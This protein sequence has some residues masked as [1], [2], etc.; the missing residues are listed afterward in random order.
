MVAVDSDNEEVESD[1]GNGSDSNGKWQCDCYQGGCGLTDGDVCDC[2]STFG[3]CSCTTYRVLKSC[4][5]KKDT[6]NQGN[7]Y[8]Y[9]GN[10]DEPGRLNLD[11]LPEN[12]PLVECGP[13]CPCGLEC[14]NR[15]TQCRLKYVVMYGRS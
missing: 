2:V 3:R 9:S 10:D 4:Q 5:V 11:A 6:D 1:R 12:M 7:F 13:S 8:A 14:L 15:V